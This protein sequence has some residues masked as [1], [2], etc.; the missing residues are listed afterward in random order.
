VQVSGDW[1]VGFYYQNFRGG[2]WPRWN[3]LSG[4]IDHAETISAEELTPW[5]QLKNLKQNF[6]G[7]I[8]PAEA[9]SVDVIDSAKTISAG[10]GPRW[11]LYDP[12]EISNRRYGPA[13]CLK[14]NIKQK[15]NNINT[16]YA[17]YDIVKVLQVISS[18]RR[19]E[20]LIIYRELP[21]I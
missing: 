11:N 2:H 19:A 20:T 15:L 9:V 16:D 17:K 5:K 10:H 7:F 6:N 21:V 18:L 14:E 4:V 1:L 3:N 13:I 12:A 8:D